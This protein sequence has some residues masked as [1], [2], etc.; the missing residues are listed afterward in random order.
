MAITYRTPHEY[1]DSDIW[2]RYFTKTELLILAPAILVDG[3]LIYNCFL[4]EPIEWFFAIILIIAFTVPFAVIAMATMPKN[5]PLYG[6]GIKMRK[7]ALR[8][9]LYFVVKVGRTIYVRNYNKDW[10]KIN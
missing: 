2:F 4:A 6:G 3:I 1:K 7:L 8:F 10:R 9:F 5:R